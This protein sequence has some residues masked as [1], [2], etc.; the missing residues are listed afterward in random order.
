VVTA[1]QVSEG[2]T[3]KKPPFA[4]VLLRLKNELLQRLPI[5]DP[6]SNVSE[7]LCTYVQIYFL[8]P[9]PELVHRTH[10]IAP[11]LAEYLAWSNSL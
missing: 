6:R 4:G 10:R 11:R 1:A 9:G 7:N 2:A 8:S 3:V 5:L